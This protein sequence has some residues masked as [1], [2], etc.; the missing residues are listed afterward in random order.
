MRLNGRIAVAVAS[1]GQ[2]ETTTTPRSCRRR[3][4]RRPP[5]V[6]LS[7]CRL[8]NKSTSQPHLRLHGA[9]RQRAGVCERSKHS[10]SLSRA[11]CRAVT[12]IHSTSTAAATAADAAAAAAVAL[13]DDLAVR[14]TSVEARVP[15]S[16][17]VKADDCKMH[18]TD[19]Q[20]TNRSTAAYIPTDASPHDGRDLN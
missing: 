6:R 16:V 8:I 15:T 12:V 18:C 13:V 11:R 20:P 14:C 2:G 4:P 3:R 19:C 17:G 5:S 9:D 1:S 10:L 7:V